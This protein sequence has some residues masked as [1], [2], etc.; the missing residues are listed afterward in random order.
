MS[1]PL[2]LVTSCKLFMFFAQN[3]GLVNCAMF[4]WIMIQV[5]LSHAAGTLDLLLSLTARSSAR[6]HSDFARWQFFFIKVNSLLPEV[7]LPPALRDCGNVVPDTVENLKLRFAWCSRKTQNAQWGFGPF[8]GLPVE[9][10]RTQGKR[11]TV[12]NWRGK[13]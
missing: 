2:L 1:G 13:E 4:S 8:L 6:L 11:S 3:L 12:Q 7:H 9:N 10:K 5:F